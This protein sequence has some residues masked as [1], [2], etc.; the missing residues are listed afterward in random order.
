MSKHGFTDSFGRWVEEPCNVYCRG[1]HHAMVVYTPSPEEDGM[2]IDAISLALE[3]GN[4][5]ML[6]TEVRLAPEAP[7]CPPERQQETKDP[8]ACLVIFSGGAK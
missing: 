2:P 7:P 1:D 8:I 6:V 3:W 4:P 5:G